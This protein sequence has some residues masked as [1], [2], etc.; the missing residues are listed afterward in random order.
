MSIPAGKVA[1]RRGHRPVLTI[2][3]LTG[4]AAY[5]LFGLSS[6]ALGTVT[7]AFVLAG[8]TIGIVET[9]EQGA[10]TEA[11]PE[12]IRGSAFGLLVAIQSF[13]NLA[14]SGIAGL[15]WTLVS[16]LAVFTF[17]AVVMALA[18]ISSITI[19][20]HPQPAGRA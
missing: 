8:V 3:F 14:A 19:S 1:D 7:L 17:A 18:S 15:L 9:G 10:V 5:L 4:L 12:E 2:G 6:A 11:A 13:G 20:R 16:P